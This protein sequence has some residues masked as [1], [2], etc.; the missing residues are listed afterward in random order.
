[1]NFDFNFFSLTALLI[2]IITLFIH[3]KNR[4]TNLKS[5]SITK[6]S[7]KRS[8]FEII[9]IESKAFENEHIAKLAIYNPS[10]TALILN[11]V[12]LYKKESVTNRLYNL[13]GYYYN[14]KQVEIKWWPSNKPDFTDEKFLHQEYEN[15]II[16]DMKNIFVQIPNDIERVLHK[17][18]VITSFGEMTHI[19]NITGTDSSFY[20]DF[21]RV[22]NK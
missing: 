12:K 15:L 9:F 6:D 22:G 5:F 18:E 10:S 14:W 17:F 20:L 4:F 13:F 19:T 16:K 2:S 3:I 1:M 11:C 8:F 21:K 7:H